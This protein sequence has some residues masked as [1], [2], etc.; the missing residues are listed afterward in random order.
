MILRNYWSCGLSIP[1]PWLS[2]AV[3][4]WSCRRQINYSYSMQTLRSK[5]SRHNVLKL[6]FNRF[7]W[8]PKHHHSLC[9]CLPNI[10]MPLFVSLKYP[11]LHMFFFSNNGQGYF[12]ITESNFKGQISF[13][14]LIKLLVGW[15]FSTVT[16][17]NKVGN[18]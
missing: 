15:N 9:H 18:I 4:H 8:W 7:D 16:L 1:C 13:S 14:F 6:F 5:A 17:G 11:T 10:I 2:G 12:I 3:H